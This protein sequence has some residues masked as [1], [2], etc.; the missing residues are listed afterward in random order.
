MA[1]LTLLVAVL[2]A[3][4]CTRSPVYSDESATKIIP[5]ET[6]ATGQAGSLQAPTTTVATLGDILAFKKNWDA[7]SADDGLEF[8]LAPK[9]AD[10]TIVRVDGVLNATLWRKIRPDPYSI[11]YERGPVVQEWAGIPVARSDFDPFLG[12]VVRLE[13]Q[14]YEPEQYEVGVLGVSLQVGQN[15][16]GTETDVLLGY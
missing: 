13:F 6:P 16:F 12:A 3:T 1:I 8:Y 4:G 14:D 7:D 5:S 9:D 2:L 15:S 11:V 10:D